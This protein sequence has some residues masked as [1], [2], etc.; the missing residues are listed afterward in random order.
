MQ[1]REIPT[2][3][4][5]V[6]AAEAWNAIDLGAPVIGVDC[7]G[8]LAS[9]R[10][11]W[12]RL[13]SRFP[14]EIPARYEDLQTFEWPRVTRETQA[15]CEELSAD[16]DFVTRLAPIPY[17]GEALRALHQSGYRVHI[18]TARPE[19][20]L[21]AT[22]R[23]LRMHG[24]SEHV[25]EI[26]C[27]Q[28][29]RAKVPLALELNCTTFVE[30]N[31]ATAEA[32]GLA[33]VRSYLLDAPYNRLPNHYSRRVY[34]WRRLLVDL[35]ATRDWPGAAWPEPLPPASPVFVPAGQATKVAVTH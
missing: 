10:L 2:Q 14:R 22:R 3:D 12:Q 28:D 20:V 24:V 32:M 27:V 8:V 33:S 17:M 5:E 35:A 16:R 18:I 23:W 25:E 7:D 29:G 6:I 21:G 11:L 30:D 4:W 31:Y 26:H 13:R 15:L 1:T 34:G 9:D 19:C